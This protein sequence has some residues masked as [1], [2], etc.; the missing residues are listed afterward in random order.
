M[1]KINSIRHAWPDGPQ[2]K[3][4]R[5]NGL[6]EYTFLHFFDSVEI[7][8]NGEKITTRPDACIIYNR[9]TP[10][11]FRCD[12]AIIHDWFHF[13]CDNDPV[14]EYGLS[15]DTVY[16]PSNP[17]FISPIVAE[18]ESEFFYSGPFCDKATDALVCQ[19]FVGLYRSCFAEPRPRV[20][21]DTENLFNQLRREVF[22]DLKK[23]WSVDQMA[24]FVGLSRSRFFAV[25][26][27][28]YSTTPS[29]DIINA[30]IERAK[31]MLIS[32]NKTV[33][34]IAEHLGYNNLTHF[35]RQF[36]A[37]TGTTPKKFKTQGL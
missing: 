9:K 19:L 27:A 10:Q 6:D 30:R 11:F 5:P 16:Y 14:A 18:L 35:M 28:I 15:R 1:I 4:K 3:I 2:F 12:G 21:T 32:G 26:K 31:A 8:I 24:D 33:S 23:H 17:D 22:I 34:Q 7:T 37:V 20:D 36:K 29:E 13:S 25:Y